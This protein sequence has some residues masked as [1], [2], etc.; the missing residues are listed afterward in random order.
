MCVRDCMF[1]GISVEMQNDQ[2][3]KREQEVAN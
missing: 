2:K 3:W 1:G